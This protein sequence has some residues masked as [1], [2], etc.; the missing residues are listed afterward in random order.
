M[1]N[2]RRAATGALTIDR[3]TGDSPLLDRDPRRPLL[4][5]FKSRPDIADSYDPP[6]RDT[7]CLFGA[8]IELRDLDCAKIVL[9][10][11]IVAW[12]SARHVV[13]LKVIEFLIIGP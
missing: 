1:G 13:L 12:Q 3:N 4:P 5:R 6:P 2:G 7:F 10:G 9:D 11:R 8:P